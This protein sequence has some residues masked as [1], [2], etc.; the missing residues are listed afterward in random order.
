[1]T[2]GSFKREVLLESL[3]VLFFF[4]GFFFCN[5]T[6]SRITASLASY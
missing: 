2:L 5:A 1:M 6:V 3:K 4:L